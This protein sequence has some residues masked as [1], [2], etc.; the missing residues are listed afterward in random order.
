MIIPWWVIKSCVLSKSVYLVMLFVLTVMVLI[1]LFCISHCW[2]SL[3]YPVQCYPVSNCHYFLHYLVVHTFRG[4]VLLADL[5]SSWDW[6]L[7]YAYFSWRPIAFTSLFPL[8]WQWICT[9]TIGH[10]KQLT[11]IPNSIVYFWMIWMIEF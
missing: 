11:H 10:S 9:W 4:W 5:C 3:F 2:C 7:R 8:W 6:Y 1:L